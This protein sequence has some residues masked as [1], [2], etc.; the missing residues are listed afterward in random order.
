VGDNLIRGR[1]VVG[2]QAAE[3]GDLQAVDGG[4]DRTIERSGE[5]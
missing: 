2:P 1:L 4:R 5:T 3:A